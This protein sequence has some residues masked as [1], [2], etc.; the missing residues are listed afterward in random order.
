MSDLHTNPENKCPFSR[1]GN[2]SR[3]SQIFQE[4]LLMT[5]VRNMSPFLNMC[6]SPVSGARHLFLCIQ[7]N[8]S[9]CVKSCLYLRANFL[10]LLL[11]HVFFFWNVEGSCPSSPYQHFQRA[12]W[13]PLWRAVELQ[14]NTG[15]LCDPP[16]GSAL[17][18]DEWMRRPR[19]Q[20]YGA[21]SP[22]MGQPPFCRI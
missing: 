2:N 5:Y 17:R 13:V 15:K 18:A 14:Q 6:I 3:F 9:P 10:S 21:S 20:G 4:A 12:S 1:K 16:A 19:G 7:D 11:T 22:L 8:C